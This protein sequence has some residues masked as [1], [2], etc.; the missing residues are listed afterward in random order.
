M[1]GG[2]MKMKVGAQFGR[3]RMPFRPQVLAFVYGFSP[4]QTLHRGFSSMSWRIA[5]RTIL[6]IMVIALV[7]GAQTPQVIAVRAGRLFDPKLD[8]LLTNQI[9]LI[10]GEW[11]TEEGAADSIQIPAGAHVIDLTHAT[12]LPGLIDAHTHI[13]IAGQD[14]IESI[15]PPTA[16]DFLHTTREY[17]TLVALANTQADLQAGFTTLR[18]LGNHGNMYADA[19]LRDAIN[20][21]LFVGPRMQVATRAISSTDE[22]LRG[23]RE[24]ELPTDYEI[25]DSPWSAR[26]AVEE[27]F[28]YGANVI[29]I[30]ATASKYH[31]NPDG[32][33]EDTPLLTLEE[34]QVI[35]EA[36][37]ARNLK[38][39]CHAFGGEGLTRCVEAGVDTV[40]HAIELP[41]A[42]LEKMMAKG[43]YMVPTI[44]HYHLANYTIPDRK[45]TGG[46]N[47]LALM[48]EESFKRAV[49][50]GLKIGFG[51]GVGPFPHGTQ[52][53]EFEYMVRYGMTPLQALRAAT[54]VNAEMM[55]WQDR[56]GSIEKGKFADIV[57]VSGDPLVDITELERVK[58]VMKGG[59]VVRND[60]R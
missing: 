36:A 27:Q 16:D 54:S 42:T 43:I 2:I 10:Q 28:H 47:S 8:H 49:E 44:Y 40:E 30:R 32:Q 9:V 45:A 48:R 4:S 14:S 52:T 56:V 38:V 19:D 26:R 6:V 59:H 5:V 21:G 57:A 3:V 29:K 18:D 15:G 12:V 37:H 1:R 34:I 53:K 58:F 50:R 60:F 55:G 13:F 7:L 24:L 20:R 22:S 35:V 51:T 33:F 46:K 11:I 31:F 23:S 41:N 39:A 25:V 17:R